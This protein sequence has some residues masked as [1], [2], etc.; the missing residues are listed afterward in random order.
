M[1]LREL[2][3]HVRGPMTGAGPCG[4]GLFHFLARY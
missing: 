1:F 2:L 3:R 4:K